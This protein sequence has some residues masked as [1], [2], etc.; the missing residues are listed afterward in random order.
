[1]TPAALLSFLA[2]LS[3][4][5]NTMLL[6]IALFGGPKTVFAFSTAA[7]TWCSGPE[8]IMWATS[9]LRLEGT[10]K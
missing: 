8:V 7:G 3:G 2:Y 5:S 4:P 10:Q 6:L 9:Q 1:M